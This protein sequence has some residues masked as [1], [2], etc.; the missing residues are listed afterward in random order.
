[1]TQRSCSSK[2]LNWPAIASRRVTGVTGVAALRHS[3]VRARRRSDIDWCLE[4][5]ALIR[6][7]LAEIITTGVTAA[8]MAA[9]VSWRLMGQAHSATS[10][11]KYDGRVP[12]RG[13]EA[14]FLS[15]HIN[16]HEILLAGVH[17]RILGDPIVTLRQ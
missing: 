15:K 9:C 6:M 14:N 13:E 5:I 7:A 10:I 12:R 4:L 17:D 1:V 2:S 11:R 16:I 3:A 8:E